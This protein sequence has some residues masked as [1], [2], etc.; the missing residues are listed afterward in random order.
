MAKISFLECTKC[1][2]QLSA[3]TPQTL[4]TKCAGSLYVRYDLQA[5]RGK[6]KPETLAGRVASMWRYAKFSRSEPV[7]LA[8]ASH[9]SFPAAKPKMF[10][11]KTKG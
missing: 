11:S 3:E 7:T 1:K 2:H 9:R 6:F 8:K 5:L 4:C 10:G